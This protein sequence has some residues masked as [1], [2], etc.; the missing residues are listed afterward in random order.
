MNA[1]RLSRKS[2]RGTWRGN[3]GNMEGDSKG[4]RIVGPKK[5]VRVGLMVKQTKNFGEHGNL[6]N[7][8][9]KTNKP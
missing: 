9:K 1:A 4:I 2:G 6:E 5:M 7:G 3:S 8:L